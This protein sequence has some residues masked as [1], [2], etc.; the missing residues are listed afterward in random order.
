MDAAKS[1][2]ETVNFDGLGAGA[3]AGQLVSIGSDDVRWFIE[4][5]SRLRA[6]LLGLDKLA[7]YNRRIVPCVSLSGL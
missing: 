4:K 5:F 3:W 1:P 6:R 7:G 2:S